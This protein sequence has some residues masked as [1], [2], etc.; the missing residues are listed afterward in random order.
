[1]LVHD[2]NKRILG[3]VSYKRVEFITTQRICPRE[4]IFSLFKKHPVKTKSDVNAF[5]SIDHHVLDAVCKVNKITHIKGYNPFNVPMD[6]VDDYVFHDVKYGMGRSDGEIEGGVGM[7]VK[8]PRLFVKSS[9]NQNILD[10]FKRNSDVLAL[11]SKDEYKSLKRNWKFYD[12]TCI[13]AGSVE[14]V[15]SDHWYDRMPQNFTNPTDMY[16]ISRQTLGKQHSV[17][18]EDCIDAGLVHAA[19]KKSKTAKTSKTSKAFKASKT[20]KLTSE[21]VT[22]QCVHDDVVVYTDSSIIDKQIGI[23]IW[24][25]DPHFELQKYMYVEGVYDIDINRGE[26]LAI[27]YALMHLKPF[28]S[29]FLPLNITIMT[30][31][32]TAIKLLKGTVYCTK[33]ETIVTSILDLIRSWNGKITI[34]KVKGH[35][36]DIGNDNADFLARYGVVNRRSGESFLVPPEHNSEGDFWN[37]LRYLNS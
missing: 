17:A 10:D 32:I 2:L 16:I 23:G 9:P 36:G 29:H 14:C 1:M 3:F 22:D 6:L 21:V 7:M 15:E 8:N 24:S 26:L 5:M 31:S 25:E 27:L 18:I 33:F 12:V 11:V 28:T 4:H 37:Y 20:L 13:P 34:K 30:D 19:K 35:S